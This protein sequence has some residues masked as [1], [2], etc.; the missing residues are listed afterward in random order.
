M[1]ETEKKILGKLSMQD[2]PPSQSRSPSRSS[3]SVKY[4]PP[5]HFTGEGPSVSPP[6]RP[7]RI[8]C[9]KCQDYGHVER[10][11]PTSETCIVFPNDTGLGH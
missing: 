5:G 2:E 7:G 10:D 6:N 9:L 1:E 8:R 4:L 3:T 11:C